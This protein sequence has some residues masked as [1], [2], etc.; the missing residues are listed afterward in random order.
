MRLLSLLFMLLVSSQSMAAANGT[1]IFGRGG[2]SVTLDP[3]VSTDSESFNV[4]DHIYETLVRF[5]NGTTVIEPGL[6][7]TWTVSADGLT[8]EF[9][10]RSGVNFH[11][12]SPLTADAV[13]YKFMR[14]R[15]Y[16]LFR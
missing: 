10:I 1:L 7:E 4:T 11:D 6:A 2:D 16:K 3:A 13:V 5:R 8:Y 14:S 12:G 15:V 9:K